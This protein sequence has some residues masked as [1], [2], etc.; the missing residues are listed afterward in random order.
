MN[1]QEITR[2]FLSI[3]KSTKNLSNKT[4]TAYDSDLKDFCLFL[5]NRQI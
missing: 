1:T 3:L 5:N 2:D 4:M